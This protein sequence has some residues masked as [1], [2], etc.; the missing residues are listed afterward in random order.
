V[1]TALIFGLLFVLLTAAGC[2]GSQRGTLLVAVS[3][4]SGLPVRGA[5]IGVYGTKLAGATDASGNARISGIAPGVYLVTV[6]KAGY[7]ARSDRETIQRRATAQLSV[8][9]NYVPP[10]GTFWQEQNQG[11]AV[12]D[13]LSITSTA[14]LRAT[15]VRYQ[16]VCKAQYKLVTPPPQ[17]PG[18]APLNSYYV[19]SGGTWSWQKTA[20]DETDTVDLVGTAVGGPQQLASGW[21]TGSP[22]I[23]GPKTWGACKP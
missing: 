15:D 5:H 7:Y 8:V 2:G 1:R 14:P 16:Q 20:L 10:I 12:V 18:W 4:P 19:Q 22:P 17:P 21:H 6:G 3:D 9:L 11:P 13:V 23:G